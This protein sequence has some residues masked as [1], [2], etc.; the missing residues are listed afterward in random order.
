MPL[1]KLKNLGPKSSDMLRRAGIDTE[2]QL[3][4]L[5]P[6]A[7]FLTVR[8][9]NT[10]V[11]LNLLWAIAGALNNQHWAQL[12]PEYKRSLKQELSELGCDPVN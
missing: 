2:S 4:D 1:A 3:R 5:G 6:A 12:D 11:S 10:N 7:A 9:F 8:R